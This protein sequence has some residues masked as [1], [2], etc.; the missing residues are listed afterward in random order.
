MTIKTGPTDTESLAAQFIQIAH[1]SGVLQQ[2][3]D[4]LIKS[5]DFNASNDKLLFYICE[6]FDDILD[7]KQ[8]CES[9]TKSLA[10]LNAIAAEIFK[11]QGEA[12]TEALWN[13]EL[14][15]VNLYDRIFEAQCHKIGN[16]FD[17]AIKRLNV[18]RKEPSEENFRAAD[19]EISNL[20]K[21]IPD[22]RGLAR[23]CSLTLEIKSRNLTLEKFDQYDL[24]AQQLE[25]LVEV[26][27][28][29]SLG[30]LCARLNAACQEDEIPLH[31]QEELKE[32]FHQFFKNSDFPP[33]LMRALDTMIRGLAPQPQDGGDLNDS[34][35]L[36]E[37]FDI[38]THEPALEP[39]DGRDWDDQWHRYEDLHRFKRALFTLLTQDFDNHPESRKILEFNSTPSPE[40]VGPSNTQTPGWF[41]SRFPFLI[42]VIKPIGPK[43]SYLDSM[44]HFDE[45]SSEEN[46]RFAN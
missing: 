30:N 42:D 18:C 9:L 32:D 14:L 10:T 45:F 7:Q 34:D 2:K 33:R 19:L 24:V 5:A 26:Y 22:I 39:K 40:T 12:I 25:K 15:A 38:I 43:F 11:K 8:Q 29:G 1:N 17:N 35:F 4:C 13:S 41:Q 36:K 46:E 28:P 20:C 21:C 23:R 16:Q 37:A 3:S 44:P 31:L 6:L 27:I